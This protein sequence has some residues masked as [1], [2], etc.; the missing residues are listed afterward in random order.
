MGDSGSPLAMLPKST[1]IW[2][3]PTRS[4][5]SS[6]MPRS[7]LPL[8][9]QPRSVSPVLPQPTPRLPVLFRPRL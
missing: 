7:A 9:F 4:L 6:L 3:T 5:P 1:L 2:P 8:L